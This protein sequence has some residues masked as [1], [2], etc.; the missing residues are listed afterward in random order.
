MGIAKVW[1]LLL[2]SLLLSILSV[3]VGFASEREEIIIVDDAFVSNFNGQHGEVMK[4][5]NR[6]INCR[7]IKRSLYEI[8]YQ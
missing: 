7:K 6:E 2:G 4:E 3:Q 1:F 8:S 5:R